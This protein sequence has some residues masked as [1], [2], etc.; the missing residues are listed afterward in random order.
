MEF[1]DL[2]NWRTNCN[3]CHIFLLTFVL[4]LH[5]NIDVRLTNM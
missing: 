5:D 1:D 2:E 3:I 4:S